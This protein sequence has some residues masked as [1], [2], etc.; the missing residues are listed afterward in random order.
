M[1]LSFDC[2]VEIAERLNQDDVYFFAACSRQFYRA[3]KRA[4]RKL[5]TRHYSAASSILKV[6]WVLERCPH[7]KNFICEWAA[8][9]TYLDV[10][11]WARLRG[12]TYYY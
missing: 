1:N 2:L 12:L 9:G 5:H 11:K 7:F 3:S 8:R 10:L 4:Q 6:Q